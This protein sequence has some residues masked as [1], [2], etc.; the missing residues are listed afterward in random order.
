[1]SFLIS[2]F[3]LKIE[4]KRSFINDSETLETQRNGVF[5]DSFD[6]GQDNERENVVEIEWFVIVGE[7]AHLCN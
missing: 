5:L 4:N 3:N 6:E 2:G 7:F 1:L